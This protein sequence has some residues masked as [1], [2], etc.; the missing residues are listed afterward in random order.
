MT[1]FWV[2]V[3]VQVW[4][5]GAHL[6]ITPEGQTIS[7][8]I[9]NRLQPKF[10]L[11]TKTVKNEKECCKSLVET[12]IDRTSFIFWFKAFLT[13]HYA[14][15]HLSGWVIRVHQNSGISCWPW[16]STQA[17]W[18]GKPCCQKIGSRLKPYF[19]VARYNLA[20][21]KLYDLMLSSSI[22]II[23]LLIDLLPLT[24]HSIVKSQYYHNWFL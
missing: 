10:P 4:A 1:D 7:V 18:K 13:I 23:K 17:I 20:P 24:N 15:E 16:H 9:L 21:G 6:A 19:K 14:T 22:K 8:M 5:P 11:A 2:Q 12:C 3:W